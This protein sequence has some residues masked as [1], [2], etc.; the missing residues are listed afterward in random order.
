MK[1]Q[2]I[3][4]GDRVVGIVLIFNSHVHLAGSRMVP[5]ILPMIPEPPK[6][7]RVCDVCTANE[8]MVFCRDHGQYLCEVCLNLHNQSPVFCQYLSMTAARE[9]LVAQTRHEAHT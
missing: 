5:M 1:F 4:L 2:L 7:Q 3:R 6:F 9:M 8:A